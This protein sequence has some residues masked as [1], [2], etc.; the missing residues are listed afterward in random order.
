MD[1]ETI[2][3][4]IDTIEEVGYCVLPSVLSTDE[5]DGMR[6][7][8]DTLRQREGR[9]AAE[10]ALDGNDEGLKAHGPI[11]V[12]HQRVVHIAAKHR[13]FLELLCHPVPL[14]IWER[15]LGADC[16]CSTWTS[17]TV[18]PKGG[19]RH[20][21]VDH[22][23]WTMVPP[24]PAEPLTG[25]TIWCLDDFTEDNGATRFIPGSHRHT[26]LP[27][28]ARDQVQDGDVV[29]APR[30]SVILAHG[31]CWHSMGRNESDAPR[32]AVFGRFARSY[33][34]PQEEMR[35]QLAGFESPSALVQRLFGANQYLPSKGIPY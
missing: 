24:F 28:H 14:A 18:L 25:Q 17:N 33:I 4:I 10:V 6:R 8:I 30:G 31:A 1:H 26:W 9:L 3:K 32:T 5:A 34:I 15:M 11:Q 13:A 35:L 16:I 23:Y 29:V 19:K 7:V 27:D 20:W 21:H 2:R 12:G 22:P